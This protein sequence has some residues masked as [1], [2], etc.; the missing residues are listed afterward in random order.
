MSYDLDRDARL[1]GL[2]AWHAVPRLDPEAPFERRSRPVL[3]VH[4]RS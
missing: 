2:T 1:A 4:G 3:F